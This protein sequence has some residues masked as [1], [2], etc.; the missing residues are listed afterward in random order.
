MRLA[1]QTEAAYENEDRSWLGSAHGTQ[2]ARPI[3]LDG[4]TF[5]ATFADGIVPSGV[6][7]GIITAT[8][9]Y[10]PYDDAAGDGREV[11]RGHLYSTVEVA[12]GAT[13]DA[14]AALFEH[15]RVYTPNLPTGHG[16][17]AAARVDLR[18]QIIYVD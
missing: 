15:G 11:A 2:N 12:A 7:L 13:G 8:G 17:N 3:T 16:L 18:G 1:Q 4:D 10:G 5:L 14:G 6:V 9:L